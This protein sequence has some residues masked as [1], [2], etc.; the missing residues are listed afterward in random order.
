MFCC[1][2]RIVSVDGSVTDVPDGEANAGFFGRPS[3]AS[4]DG[5]FPQVR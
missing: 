5:A 2:L 3:N 4:R 1:G